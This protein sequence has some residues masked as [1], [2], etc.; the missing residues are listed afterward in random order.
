MGTEQDLVHSYILVK[1]DW[2][3]CMNVI[4][5]KGTAVFLLKKSLASGKIKNW[6]DCEWAHTRWSK[7]RVHCWHS[8]EKKES[9]LRRNT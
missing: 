9:V 5:L 7:V 6:E 1:E 2:S 3:E 4:T 8:T